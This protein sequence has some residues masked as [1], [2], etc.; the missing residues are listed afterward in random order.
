MS[1]KALVT[2]EID[3]SLIGRIEA[4]GYEVIFDGWGKTHQILTEEELINLMPGVALLMVEVEKVTERVMNASPDLAIIHA[5]RSQPNNVDVDAATERGIGVISA[6]GRNAASVA[7]FTIGI[8]LSL[9]RNIHRAERHLRESGWHV[10]ED[11]P[12]FHFRGPELTGKTLGLVGCGAI[13]REILKRL[14]GFEMEILIY[15]PYLSDLIAQ[16]LGKPTSLDTL[17]ADS[18]FVLVLCALTPETT[19]MI[20]AAQLALMKPRA[21]L[22]NPARAAVVDEE[23][24]LEVLKEGRIAGAALDVFWTEPLSDDSPWFDRDNVL[25]TPHLGG[26][27]DDVRS[28]HTEML[29][30]DLLLL[31]EGKLPS[32]MANPEVLEMKTEQE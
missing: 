3:P 14:S 7:D 16:S 13:G 30:E 22:I 10:G 17:M 15:D 32:R 26:A 12:Y 23:A 31:E 18:D 28:H 25:L 21:Y 4:L 19:S 1:G 2:A 20:G 8:L 27:S 9:V 5:C 11:I 6:P 29:I 24:L